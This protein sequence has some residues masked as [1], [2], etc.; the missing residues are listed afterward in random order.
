[1]THPIKEILSKRHDGIS[2]GIASYCTS[3]KIVIE[4][5]LEYYLEKDRVTEISVNDENGRMFMI[6]EAFQLLIKH[7]V[8]LWL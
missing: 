4:S 1:M 2:S 8:N 6:E 7:F 3:N 5:I